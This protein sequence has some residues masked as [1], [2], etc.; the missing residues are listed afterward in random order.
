MAKDE[1]EFDL[2]VVGYGIAGVAAAIEAVDRGGRVLVL[3]RGHGGGAAGLSGG[4]V[5]AGGGTR[6]QRAAG[7]EDTP[8]N[9]F[10]YLRQETD[11]VVSD[12]TLRR[13]CDSSV[14]MI[15]W[16]EENGAKFDSTLCPYKTSYPTDAHYLYYSGNEKAWPYKEH[17]TPAARGH[18]MVA[19]G[20]ASGHDLHAALRETA[21]RKGVEFR[22]LSRVEELIVEDGTVRGVR[23]RRLSPDDPAFAKHKRFAFTGAKLSN[24]MPALGYKVAERN[25][26][27]WS[28]AAKPAESRARAVLLSAGGFVYNPEMKAEYAGGFIDIQPLGTEGDDGTGIKLGVGAGG[29]TDHMER[30]TAW[31]FMSPPSA[32]LKGVTVGPSGARIANEDLYG[33]THSQA[34][35]EGHEAKGWLILDS[36][37]W[38]EARAQVR[39]QSLGFQVLLALYLFTSGHKKAGSI[40]ALAKKI[41]LPPEAVAATIEAYNAGIASGAGDPAH[42]AP[43]MC[44]PIEEGPFY[45]ID[46]SI[47]NS[48]NYPAPGLTLGGLRVDEA[49]GKVLKEGGGTVPG[50]YAAGRNAIGIASNGYISGISLA[51]GVFSGRRAAADVVGGSSS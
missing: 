45:A 17:A 8:E 51:D 1:I 40:A 43:D 14:E 22:P 23:Y 28:A 36:R 30:M 4:V 24:W 16:L 33:A 29:M 31:R 42:K 5:Y 37:I 50:L 26:K 34:M 20:L 41:D 21:R 44:A 6:H 18:R 39:S 3:D 48:P 12:E 10:A 32:F 35:I 19:K 46:I 7:E 27:I 13:F 47:K 2:L 15:D 9:M 38:K 25:D 11:G 49:T